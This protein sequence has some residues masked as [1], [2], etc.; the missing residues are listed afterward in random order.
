[1]IGYIWMCCRYREMLIALPFLGI[2]AFARFGGLRFTIFAIPVAALSAVFLFL[3]VAVVITIGVERLAVGA[4]SPRR[5]GRR[6]DTRSRRR[7]SRAARTRARSE[8]GSP[9]RAV[10]DRL[11]LLTSWRHWPSTFAAVATLLLLVPNIKHIVAYPAS[12]LDHDAVAALHAIGKN[13]DGSDFV[14]TWW[15][16]GSAAWYYS[17]YRTLNSPASNSSHDNF[18]VS[19]ILSTDSQRQ[20]ANLCRDSVEAFVARKDTRRSAIQAILRRRPA[21]PRIDPAK[22]LARAA[23]A[24][25]VPAAKTREVYLFLPAEML[26][27]FN[28]IHLF[29]NRDLLTG[30][31]RAKPMYE[32][33]FPV[34]FPVFKGGRAIPVVLTDST[35]HGSDAADVQS[36]TGPRPPGAAG[37]GPANSPVF[38][39]PSKMAMRNGLRIDLEKRMAS[40]RGRRLALKALHVSAY[41]KDSRLKIGS[42]P[43]DANGS[44]HVVYVP[45]LGMLLLMDAKMFQSALVQ[46]YLFEDYDPSL[47]EPVNVSV[48]ARIY[49]LKI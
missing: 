35:R 48:T 32:V 2:G 9:P 47:F 19:Q 3:I 36:P 20:A 21:A 26:R 27:L 43:F 28:A 18:V 12:F 45:Q 44:C 38:Q 33:V 16:Y 17:G 42:I 1:L 5:K 23:S 29:S 10:V 22:Y 4:R 30:K 8:R 39:L 25:Y 11:R 13:G 37:G 46:M 6:R 15:D 34:V 24:D 31:P 49:R 41:G 14:I 40:L 7:R